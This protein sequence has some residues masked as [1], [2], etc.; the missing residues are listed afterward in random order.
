MMLF[1]HD[2]LLLIY[3]MPL[4]GFILGMLPALVVWRFSKPRRKKTPTIEQ[5][6]RIKTGFT[7]SL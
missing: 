4:L 2:T 5:A 6:A 7:L 1:Q 3:L